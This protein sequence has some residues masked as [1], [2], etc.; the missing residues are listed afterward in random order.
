MKNFK[1]NIPT[2]VLAVLLSMLFGGTALYAVTYPMANAFMESS[3]TGDIPVQN[4]SGFFTGTAPAA[5]STQPAG[6][7]T[8]VQYNDGGV[9]G[10]EAAFTYNDGLNTVSADV[11]AGGNV[12][13]SADV[14]AIDNVTAGAFMTAGTS[15]TGGTFIEAGS[16]FRLIDPTPNIGGGLECLFSNATSG[17]LSGA[18]GTI[19][20][21]VPDGARVLGVQLRVDTAVTGPATFGASYS[22]G[23]LQ[24]ID[25]IMAVAKNTKSNAM[26]DT[27]TDDDVAGGEV[28]ITLS[29]VPN[30]TGGV[31]RAIVY[32]EDFIAMDNNP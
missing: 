29:A 13:A 24:L 8:E 5:I 32:Y 19:E 11:F 16:D 1:I 10:A 20:V 23:L 12:T 27:N 14:D 7:D 21:N 28:D 26:F 6:N 17:A 9:M 2:V 4:A 25:P 22:G 31:V 3:A 15:I 18:T 30:F